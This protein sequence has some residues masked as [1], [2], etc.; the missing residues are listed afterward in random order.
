MFHKMK[1][2]QKVL[3][4]QRTYRIILGFPDQ[5]Q[6]DFLS[7]TQ[8]DTIS[9]FVTFTYI[10]TPKKLSHNLCLAFSSICF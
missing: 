6:S 3:T 7:E 10:C 2:A 4:L 8:D 9:I 1:I 5:L